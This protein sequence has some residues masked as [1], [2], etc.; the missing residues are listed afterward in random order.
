MTPEEAREVLAIT[1][2]AG[3]AND[4]RLADFLE[5]QFN[6]ADRTISQVATLK[7]INESG[8]LDE[9]IGAV[10]RLMAVEGNPT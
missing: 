8:Q 5:R 1:K 3:E 6:A 10:E 7:L 4:Q 9:A 2:E